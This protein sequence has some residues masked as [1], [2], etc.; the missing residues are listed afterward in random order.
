MNFIY[1]DEGRAAARI[2]GFTITADNLNRDLELNT[3]NLSGSVVVTYKNQSFKSDFLTIDQNKHQAVLKGNV[4]IFT[5]DVEIGGDEVHLDYESDQSVIYNGYVKSNNIRFQGDLIE[6]D[7]VKSFSILNADYTTCNNCPASW[8]FAGTKIKAELGGY[9]F[10]KNT[11]LKVNDFPV[12]WLPYL[13]VPLKNERQ[14]GLLNPELGYINNRNLVLSQSF[15]WA[16]NRSEDL[17]FTF[18]NY[19]LGGVKQLIEYRY[20]INDG[21]YG[22]IN[23]SH[24]NDSVFKSDYRYNFFR[25][26]NKKEDAFNRWAFKAEQK[27]SLTEDTKIHLRIHQISDLQ[28]PKDFFDE[29]KN[30]AESGLENRFTL[31]SAFSNSLFSTDL[32]YFNHLLEANPLSD[33]SSAVHKLPEIRLDTQFQKINDLPVY[34]KLNIDGAQFYRKKKYDDISFSSDGQKYISNSSNNPACDHQLSIG[35]LP[36][37]C[38]LLE[39][40]IYNED[41]DILRTGQRVNF[42]TTFTTPAYTLSA[43]NI[44]PQLSYTDTQYFFQEGS[45]R[46]NHRKFAELNVLSRSKLFNIYE[47]ND[48][49]LNPVDTLV[50]FKHELIPEVTYTWIP[51]IDQETHPFFGSY[52]NSDAPFKSADEIKDTDI[53]TANQNSLQFDTYDRIYERHI[54]RFS[55]LNRLIKKNIKNLTYAPI[56]NFNL[57]QS[58]DLYQTQAKENINKPLSN[59][60]ATFN[61]YL[62][63]FS[64]DQQIKYSPYQFATDST[65][66][67]IYRNINGQ[68]FKLGYVSNRI[69]ASTKVDD[70]ALAVGFVTPYLNLVTGIIVD[71][72]ENRNSDSR[73]K[74]HSIIAQ[75]KPPGECWGINFFR[76]QKIGVGAEWKLKFVFSFDGKP[77]KVIPPDELQ[78]TY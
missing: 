50:K 26:A 24:M 58:Y 7:S 55:I 70:L 37:D 46:Y 44:T 32:T 36:T 11:F 61:V 18:K 48:D 45:N 66:T 33:N 1:A 10:L 9:A 69:N 38:D 12:L 64:F 31:S 68:Y 14:S 5:K 34:Y 27:H 13:V 42:K 62:N 52:Q 60:D 56:L 4:Q 57:S 19:E 28:Y 3:V 22:E 73:L 21:S 43:I 71:T 16:I 15:F 54:I 6:Q 74:K 29:F 30:Y 77:Q 59:L 72:S 23:A 8:S 41:T 40:G 67:L 20:I 53:N 63:S 35:G 49:P 47:S 78:L 65:S 51:W 76:D 25:P 39:D 2:S 75:F 17:T